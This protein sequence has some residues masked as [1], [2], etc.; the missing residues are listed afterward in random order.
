MGKQKLRRTYGKL[1]LLFVPNAGQTERRVRYYAQGAGFA[2][3]LTKHKAVLALNR[4]KRGE[5]LELRF[6]GANPNPRLEAAH[7]V[8]G[9]VNYLTGAHRYTNLPTYQDVTYRNLWPGID[10]VLR[11][12]AG[13]LEY[14][15]LVRPG[16]KVGDI[17][18]AYE[19]TSGI[20]IDRAGELLIRTPLGTLTDAAPRSY[21]PIGGRTVAVG[22]HFVLGRRADGKRLY[23]FRVAGYDPRHPLVIDPGL[24]YSTFLGGTFDDRGLDIALDAQGDAYVAGTTD[25]PD[26][27]T[28]PGAFATT[29]HGNGDVFVTKLNPS[30]SAPVYSTYLGGTASEFF[31]SIAIDGQGNAYVTGATGQGPSSGGFPVTPGAFDTTYHGVGDAFVAKL[32]ASGST[33]LYSTFLG[34][35]DFES[36]ESIAVDALGDAYVAGSTASSDFP[37]TAGAFDTTPNG[38]FDAFVTKLNPSGTGLVYSTYLG[39]GTAGAAAPLDTGAD[40]AIDA[41]GNAYVTG[42]TGSTDFPTTPGAFDQSYNGPSSGFE[43]GDV[44]V[45]KLAPTGSS[46]VYSTYLGGAEFEEI[47]GIAVDGQGNAYVLGTTRS[48]NFPTTGGAYDTTLSGGEDAFVTKLNAAGSG[49]AYSTYLGGSSLDGGGVAAGVGGGGVAVDGT[50]SAYVTGNTFS[51]D[52]PTTFGAFDQTL[53]GGLD[54][55]VTKLNPVGSDLAYSSY[56]GGTDS[57]EGASVAIGA[58]GDAYLTG[59]TVSNDFPTTPGAFDTTFN[60]SSNLEEDAFVTTVV[61]PGPPASLILAPKAATNA[62]GSQHCSTATVKDAFGRATPGVIVRFSVTG[63]VSTSGIG[64]TN[65]SGQASFCYT[66]PELPGADA[67]QAFADTDKNGSQGT[68]E[69]GDTATKSWVLP[70]STPLCKVTLDGQ[71]TATNGDKATFDGNA[72][73]D[74]S[75][76]PSGEETYQ[77]H[78]PAQP[79]TVKQISV[80]ALVCSPDGK[81]AGI[82]GKAAINGSGSFF[83]KIDLQDLAEP[84]IGADTYRI[85]LA[86][87][88]DSGV[89][90]LQ[91]GNVQIHFG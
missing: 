39:G 5:A 7:P 85:L 53:N 76:K 55:Y 37:T 29:Y 42:D 80:L 2:F 89:H 15:F 58:Q 17:G 81:Q 65:T 18:L 33:L 90:T 69:P 1:P 38:D 63:S 8:A 20:S 3:Y 68:T 13:K 52:F 28:T 21:Q 50:G 14:E 47:G 84:G 73:V 10:M 49:L 4:G 31:P 64:T 71:I 6:R 61:V 60:S 36:G 9:K 41:S 75:G 24:A 67:I 56:L 54:A 27:P 48:A 11:G 26:F 35:S 40:I 91:G 77:D 44:F 25:S 57:E 66:G 12:R 83:Y 79:Q 30:G 62:V 45:T 22:S 88:Y 16:A 70:K 23:G 86:T 34:G 78:G 51:T 87:G 59:L 43:T 82:F 72:K 19:G 32:S 74:G 46:L